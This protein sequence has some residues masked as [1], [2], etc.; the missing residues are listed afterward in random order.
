[1]SDRALPAG[2]SPRQATPHQALEL[3]PWHGGAYA[4]LVCMTLG[5]TASVGDSAFTIMALGLLTLGFAVGYILSIVPLSEAIRDPIAI[6]AAGGM[7]A[8]VYLVPGTNSA[9]L[10]YD[11]IGDEDLILAVR[12]MT[13]VLVLGPMTCFRPAMLF[14]FVFA[15]S[16]MGLV[17]QINLNVEAIASFL[18]FVL[19]S[20]FFLGYDNLRRSGTVARSLIS[21]SPARLIADQLYASALVFVV[22]GSLGFVVGTIMTYGIRS[23][24][25][26]PPMRIGAGE[27]MG[28]LAGVSSPFTSFDSRLSLGAGPI[29]DDDSPVM[30][31]QASDPMLYRARVYSSYERGVWQASGTQGRV[32]AAAGQVAVWNE[33]AGEEG[34]HQEEYVIYPETGLVNLLACPAVPEYLSCS[35]VSIAIDEQGCAHPDGAVGKGAAIYGRS[36]INTNDPDVLRQC[37]TDFDPNVMAYA[38]PPESATIVALA[39]SVAGAAPTSYDRVVALQRHIERECAYNLRAARYSRDKDPVEQFLFERKEGTCAE[40]ASALA[41]LA[42]SLGIPARVAGGFS[43]GDVDPS[44]GLYHIG[45]R[46]AHAWTEV[47]FPGIGWVPF[48]PQAE[49]VIERSS[50]R[51]ILGSMGGVVGGLARWLMRHILGL[52]FV[53][54]V[55]FVMLYSSRWLREL[56]R[57]RRLHAARGPRNAAGRIYLQLCDALAPLSHA[58]APSDAPEEYLDRLRPALARVGGGLP[59]RVGDLTAEITRLRYAAAEPS[60]DEISA[61]KARILAVRSC[62]REH[63]RT[64]RTAGPTSRPEVATP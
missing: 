37:G 24:F 20:L 38:R 49:R 4:A 64:E 62:V 59:A 11:V 9:L 61:L 43:S 51:D 33:P 34:E 35:D 17:G 22:L 36:R 14:C 12:V 19:F 53:V 48:D 45:M 8:L 54:P 23:P 3:L 30:E 6:L 39:R 15:L 56:L 52:V 50:L 60:G 16:V 58:R 2:A 25:G 44:T 13:G 18:G 10:N 47:H 26:M 31:V 55:L 28:G 42:R 40:F 46:N 21:L 1:L 27:G 57:W 29:P 32:A 63:A 5:V 41:L 7:C